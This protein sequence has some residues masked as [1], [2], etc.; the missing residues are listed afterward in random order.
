MKQIRILYLKIRNRKDS[1][2]LDPRFQGN[3]NF[4]G[5]EVG[6]KEFF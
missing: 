6:L 1:I 3:E 2:Y 5:N 4:N